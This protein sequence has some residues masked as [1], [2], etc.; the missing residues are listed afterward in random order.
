[1]IFYLIVYL[2]IGLQYGY[3]LVTEYLLTVKLS[4]YKVI[5][6]Y[7]AATLCMLITALIWP[8]MCIYKIATY[9]ERG[10]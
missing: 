3:E 2:L 7:I 10:S 9:F 6:I 1:M 4:G 5:V 8:F